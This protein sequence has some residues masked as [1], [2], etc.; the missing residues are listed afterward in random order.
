MKIAFEKKNKSKT[1]A[2]RIFLALSPLLVFNLILVADLLFF[3]TGALSGIH[4]PYE[5]GNDERL[6]TAKKSNRILSEDGQHL[7]TY[8]GEEASCYQ[9]KTEWEMKK[10]LDEHPYGGQG[11]LIMGGNLVVNDADA[12][13]LNKYDSAG[14][15]WIMSTSSEPWGN[16]MGTSYG[17]TTDVLYGNNLLIDGQVKT[18]QIDFKAAS[19]SIVYSKN[20][21]YFVGENEACKADVVSFINNEEDG[22]ANGI[23][24]V[25][26]G[27]CG[28]C[29]GVCAA[30]EAGRDYRFLLSGALEVKENTKVN[31]QIRLCGYTADCEKACCR[32]AQYLFDD[33]HDSFV[34]YNCEETLCKV[35]M[36]TP[37]RRYCHPQPYKDWE[38]QEDPEIDDVYDPVEGSDYWKR[39]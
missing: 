24:V 29:D 27:V 10:C 17:T 18:G 22:S 4:D 32:L 6:Y 31:E 2:R 19:S 37:E 14:M 15:N 23:S 25:D 13:Y 39:E 9:K 1:L 7:F 26:Q 28:I 36:L 5:W 12:I 34:G 21:D 33:I 16:A 8:E 38:T 3:K 35:E 20:K 30:G 11:T